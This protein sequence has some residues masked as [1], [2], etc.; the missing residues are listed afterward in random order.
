MRI[1]YQIQIG[2]GQTVAFEIGEDTEV[3]LDGLKRVLALASDATA[4][5]RA[6]FELPFHK[7]RLFANREL[8]KSQLRE[9]AKADAQMQARVVQMTGT[10][11]NQVPPAQQDVNTVAQFDNRI[12]E[13]QKTIRS[14]ELRIPYLEAVIA[15]EKP[16]EL[17]PE[18]EDEPQAMAAE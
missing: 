18:I 3:G 12:L 6:K 10:R 7:A 14:D 17:F 8:L 11:R 2:E 9:R 16:P 13:L 1:T 5:E 4:V 15:G